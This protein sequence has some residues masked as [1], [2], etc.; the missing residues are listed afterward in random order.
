MI[1]IGGRKVSPI[2]IERLLLEHPAIKTCA[3]VGIPDPRGITGQAAKAFLVLNETGHPRPDVHDL[4]D[5]LLG[6]LE[7]YKM[8]VEYEW[9]DSLPTTTSGKIQRLSLIQKIKAS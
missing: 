3:C 2:E 1:N 8:P 4:V 6:K 9:I 5:F 7:P